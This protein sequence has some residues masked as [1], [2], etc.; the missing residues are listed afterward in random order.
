VHRVSKLLVPAMVR[1]RVCLVGDAAHVVPPFTTAGATLA[2][3][4][5]VA[6][7]RALAGGALTDAALD[8]WSAERIAAVRT[9]HAQ[10]DA[11]VR[12]TIDQPPDLASAAPA[13]LTAWGRSFLPPNGARSLEVVDRPLWTIRSDGAR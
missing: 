3:A 6:L 7:A 5:G 9:V 8:T 4:D 10:G 1:E 12:H 2:I 13:E 11:I